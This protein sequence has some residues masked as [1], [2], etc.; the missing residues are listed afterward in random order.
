MS[1]L[2]NLV[3]AGLRD[4]VVQDLKQEN[5][6][7]HTKN[8]VL[9][10]AILLEAPSFSRV[11]IGSARL[12]LAR[13]LQFPDP[14]PKCDCCSWYPMTMEQT[15]TIAK[16][17][18]IDL[19]LGSV[20]ELPL[21]KSTKFIV[22]QVTGYAT[23]TEQAALQISD[24]ASG[25][26]LHVAIGPI[27]RQKAKTLFAK[28]PRDLKAFCQRFHDAAPTATVEIVC[29]SIPNRK[30]IPLLGKGGLTEDEARKYLKIPS[31]EEEEEKLRSSQAAVEAD[32]DGTKAVVV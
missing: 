20:P 28:T 5:E 15:L 16:L 25:G 23:E 11:E 1:D 14:Q 32:G 19:F 8:V 30:A 31:K 7:L 27:P 24:V 3:L 22:H 17:A 12:V 2:A 26:T 13:S 18:E 6:Q 10:K 9:A 21:S 29:F 4:K